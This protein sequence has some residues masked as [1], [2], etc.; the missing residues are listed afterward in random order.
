VVEDPLLLCVDV[1]NTSVSAAVF[2]GMELVRRTH[3]KTSMLKRG[4]DWISWLSELRDQ[5]PIPSHI[6]VATVVPDLRPSIF[7]ASEGLFEEAPHFL[8]HASP[9]GIQVAYRDPS[10]V[11][12]DRLANAVHAFE[13]LGGPSVVVDFGTANTLDLIS[14]EGRYEG[15]II[16]PGIHMSLESLHTHT[17]LLPAVDFEAP[18]ELIGKDTVSSILSG[19]YYG[20]AA[21][22]DG[23]LDR[24][25][26]CLGER[27]RVIGTGGLAEMVRRESRWI[28]IVDQ[29]ITLKGL[30]RV[31]LRVWYGK[32]TGWNEGK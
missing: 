21:S 7:K 5:D 11:G 22:I 32:K 15:G 28:E 1:G 17:A 16:M 4:T 3:R 27:P 12:A 30:C 23:L 2:R 19:A 26:D 8:T 6:V 25:T 31:G 13:N 10:Q 18:A 9:L 20:V 14:R 29:D 24:L